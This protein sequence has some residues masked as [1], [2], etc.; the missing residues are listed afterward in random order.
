MNKKIVWGLPSSRNLAAAPDS[1]LIGLSV[2]IAGVPAPDGVYTVRGGMVQAIEPIGGAQQSQDYPTDVVV[3]QILAAF[4]G[5]SPKKSYDQVMAEKKEWDHSF[6]A[7]E[8][9]VMRMEAPEKYAALFRSKYGRQPDP[10]SDETI[11]KYFKEK[12]K[13]T[14]K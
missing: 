1:K 10:P 6:K 9:E 4:K 11:K 8:H 7:G 14:T 12:L 5:E 3:G 2:Q 13:S